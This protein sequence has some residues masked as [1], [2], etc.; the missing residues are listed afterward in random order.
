MKQVPLFVI[1]KINI[2]L[3][4]NSAISVASGDRFIND[5]YYLPLPTRNMN[6]KHVEK[7]SPHAIVKFSGLPRG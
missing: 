3:K 5:S 4:E 6:L 7:A 2:P 1:S